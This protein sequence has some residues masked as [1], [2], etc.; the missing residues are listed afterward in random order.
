MKSEKSPT[1]M[2]RCIVACFCDE[3]AA[4]LRFGSVNRGEELSWRR[5]MILVR[6]A[7]WADEGRDANAFK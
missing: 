7:V 5:H 2:G 3:K 4:L 1:R 6:T